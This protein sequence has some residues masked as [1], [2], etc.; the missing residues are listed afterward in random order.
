MGA[1]R[2]RRRVLAWFGVGLVVFGLLP[3]GDAA[4]HA[5]LEASIP[6][7]S[8]VLEEAPEAIVLDFDESIEPGLSSIEVF[9]AEALPVEVGDPV[10]APSDDTVVQ[11]S[12]PD[13]DDGVYAVVWRV[14]SADGHVVDGAFSFSIGTGGGSGGGPGGS[15]VDDLLDRVTGGARASSSVTS[16]ADV[17]R[18]VLYLGL[19]LLLGA[20]GWTLFAGGEVPGVRRHLPVVGWVMATVS[21]VALYGLY[22]AEA[23]AGTL[24]DAFSPDVWGRIDATQTGRMILVR[25]VLLLVLGVLLALRSRREA[26]WWSY[27]TLLAGLGAL[28]TLPAAGHPSA[29]SPR[30]LYIALDMVH[31]I[32]IVGWMGGLA[33]LGIGSGSWLQQERTQATVRAFSRTATVLVPVI[34]VTGVVQT[35]ELAGGFDQITDTDWGR[36]LLVKLSVVSVLVAI[37]AVSRW[38]VHQVGPGSV[39]RTVIAEAVLGVVV[40]AATANLVTLPPEPP[41]PSKVFNS[42][43]SQAGLIADITVTP[44]RVGT[45]EVHVVITPPGGSILPVTSIEARMSLPEEGVPASPVTLVPDGPNHS[46]GTITLP[47]AG[48][49]RLELIVVVTPGNTVLLSTV[50]PIP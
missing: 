25:I 17:V 4:A 37:G 20:G 12:L 22:G 11:A 35:V 30:A 15:A 45:N 9:D 28:I 13:L 3:A 1:G 49:W 8:S 34:V 27:A 21:S 19:V 10:Q 43:L 48:E 32:A 47:F 40:L 33:L 5:T 6:A 14:A 2:T 46:T 16:A 39:R 50:V 29:T 26:T 44:G 38:L 42:T 7:P 41:P 36:T 24:A 23:V 31:L 18:L